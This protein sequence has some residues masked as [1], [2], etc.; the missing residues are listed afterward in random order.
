MLMLTLCAEVV[1]LHANRVSAIRFVASTIT[2]AL[3]TL[4]PAPV[5]VLREKQ[6]DEQRGDM[7][8]AD[9]QSH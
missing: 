7:K 6:N 3:Q 4:K 9:Q 8:L 5:R 2:K 1:G